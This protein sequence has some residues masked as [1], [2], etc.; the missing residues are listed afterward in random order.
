VIFELYQPRNAPR[1]RWFNILIHGLYIPSLRYISC[2]CISGAVTRPIFWWLVEMPILELTPERSI[3]EIHLRLWPLP[4]I[5]VVQIEIGVTIHPVT[6]HPRVLKCS[7]QQFWSGPVGEPQW[8]HLQFLKTRVTSYQ[9]IRNAWNH[10]NWVGYFGVTNRQFHDILSELPRSLPWNL[11]TH[12][13]GI[14]LLETVDTYLAQGTGWKRWDWIWNTSDANLVSEF[15][16]L[17]LYLIP[18]DLYS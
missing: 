10:M 7:S 14:Q 5:M 12:P 8:E 16:T 2:T 4:Q 11:C 18:Q 9:D 1:Q 3:C 6:P 15:R 17:S 13:S